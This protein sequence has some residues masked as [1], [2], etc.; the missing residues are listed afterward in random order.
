MAPEG[1]FLS[2]QS[3]FPFHQ[4]INIDQFISTFSVIN[5]E[6]NMKIPSA[7]C[8][9]TSPKGFSPPRGSLGS[10]G[11]PR[12]R[13]PRPRLVDPS[14]VAWTQLEGPDRHISAR[15]PRKREKLLYF[16]IIHWKHISC[17]INIYRY[18]NIYVEFIYIYYMYMWISI[19][20][21]SYRNTTWNSWA[22][23]LRTADFFIAS[24]YINIIYADPWN[25]LDTGVAWSSTCNVH[26][27]S[28]KW[29]NWQSTTVYLG[30]VKAAR[31][32]LA[33]TKLTFDCAGGRILAHQWTLA[34][35]P[36]P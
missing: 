34:L 14:L 26:A 12:N 30:M 22:S 21:I 4:L 7:L 8:S 24:R 35:H 15:P 31:C 16:S 18:M 6:D 1:Q 11:E 3:V 19:L 29:F 33:T 27:K 36:I 13:D 23:R 28:A 32:Q 25:N 2:I 20:L 5:Y 17:I 9:H 10:L